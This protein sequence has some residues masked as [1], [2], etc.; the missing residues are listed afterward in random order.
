MDTQATPMH[1]GAAWGLLLIAASIVFRPH[2]R[3]VSIRNLMR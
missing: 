1:V 3:A 2:P